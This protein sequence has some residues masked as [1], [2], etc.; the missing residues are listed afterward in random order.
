MIPHSKPTIDGREARAVAR[1]LR[2]GQ[3]GCSGEVDAFER[4]LHRLVGV[5]YAFAVNSGSAALHLS[6]LS[7]RIGEGDSVILPTYCC[8]AVMNAVKYTG[9]KVIL[10]DVEESSYNIGVRFVKKVFTR[11][12]KAI[13]VPHIFGLAADIEELRSFGVPIIEDCAMAIGGKLDGRRLGSL[14]DV[15][16][17]SFYATKVM[18]TGLGGEVLTNNRAIAN[19]IL[20]LT[21]YDNRDDYKVRYNYGIGAISAAIGKIQLQKLPQFLKRRREIAEFYYSELAGLP[22]SLPLYRGDGSHI[23]YR[24]VI[25]IG[26]NVGEF[27][28]FMKRR[29]VECKRPVYKP[30]HTYFSGL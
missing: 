1:V 16:V 14:G 24:F 27:I 20:D 3:L 10:S 29:G 11:S 12:V 17:C 9:A 25:N 19:T 5:R 15:S 7:L 13:I 2:D 4:A 22:L 6:L 30:L 21:Q 18:A 23:Y 26:R 28:E 8:A